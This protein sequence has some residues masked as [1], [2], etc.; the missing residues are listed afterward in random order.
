MVTN[1]AGTALGWG[2]ESEKE[3][4]STAVHEAGHAVCSYL[5]MDGHEST[6]LSI[7]RRGETGGHHQAIQT[8]E[9]S[10]KTRDELFADL[11]W[12]LGA[13]AAE[14]TFYGNNTQGVG[15]DLQMAS[16]LAATMV[17]RWGMAPLCL[18]RDPS[19][20]RKLEIL[21]KKLLTVAGP[22]DI[23]LPPDKRRDE[24]LLIGHAFQ[25]AY[26]AVVTNK[27]AVAKVADRLVRDKEIFGNDVEAL[28][29]NA[30]L[31]KPDAAK[32]LWPTL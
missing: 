14:Q 9:R 26:T 20:L 28:L 2:Y 16:H 13:Y 17:G 27:H 1:E 29:A 12:G 5:Y 7:R 23:Q 24:A 21:G 19:E 31:T 10:F 30:G 15:G 6:R 25:V 8:E 11:V 32:Y 4:R 18:D 3:E 22:G